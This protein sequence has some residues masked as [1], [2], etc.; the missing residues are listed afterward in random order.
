MPVAKTKMRRPDPSGGPAGLGVGS[1]CGHVAPYWGI[2]A[3]EAL[4]ARP[5]A[6][7]VVGSRRF[8]V[9][10]PESGTLQWEPLEDPPSRPID[11]GTR[12]AEQRSSAGEL[13]FDTRPGSVMRIPNGW[14]HKVVYT[15]RSI[16]FRVASWTQC[17]DP[18][19]RMGLVEDC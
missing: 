4:E 7:E 14:P 2:R 6:P 13:V 12:W 10:R 19:E 18:W 11:Y 15:E 17:Q 5:A 16:G 8:H 3:A 9:V 1:A